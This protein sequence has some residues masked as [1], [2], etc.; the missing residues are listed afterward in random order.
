VKAFLLAAG[1]GT[2]MGAI[3]RTTPKCLLPVAGKPL[4]GRWF[5]L[6][7][8]A[9]VTGVLVNTHHLPE[10]VRAYV[11]SCDPPLEVELAHEPQ[12]LGSA[13]TL[14]ENRAFVAGEDRFLVV[15]ADNA[16]RVD[17]RALGLAHRAQSAATLGLFRVPDP[18]TRGIVELDAGGT[19]VGFIE[20]P[21]R[22]KSNLAWAGLLV[23]TPAL[24]DAIPEKTP[25]DLG[26]DVLPRLLGRMRGFEIDGY[27]R[28]VGTP[29]SYR[30]ACDDLEKL[31][32]AA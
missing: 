1:L 32:S 12:L 15:Y 7:A 31:G 17:L 29:E 20:K 14:R 23:G 8:Q 30:Q 9:G 16:S 10:P 21:E 13:G 2:R 6:L 4:L 27:H 26:H 22:P 3:T 5:D 11:G 18:H 24:M 25:C 28:D 19:V